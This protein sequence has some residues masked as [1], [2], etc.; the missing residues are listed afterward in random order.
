MLV[1]EFTP[2]DFVN[3]E[4]VRGWCIL[5]RRLADDLKLGEEKSCHLS[6]MWRAM[7]ILNQRS[8]ILRG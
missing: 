3:T 6:N 2:A 5:R 7:G 4:E 8:Q 1:G